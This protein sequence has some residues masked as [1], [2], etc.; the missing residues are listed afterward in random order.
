MARPCRSNDDERYHHQRNS[1]NRL[2]SDSSRFINAGPRA[3]CHAPDCAR[4]LVSLKPGYNHNQTM[5]PARLWAELTQRSARR[6]RVAPTVRQQARKLAATRRAVRGGKSI[7]IATTTCGAIGRANRRAALGR[8]GV[9]R[10]GLCSL[11]G[12]SHIRGS[13][14]PDLEQEPTRK[15]IALNS[16][17][18]KEVI[19]QFIG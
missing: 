19:P 10:A 9:R 3:G 8:V 11:S 17:M 4:V 1:L 2:A 14:L 12:M 7:S 5:R 6:R 13:L 18:E 16:F 15:P